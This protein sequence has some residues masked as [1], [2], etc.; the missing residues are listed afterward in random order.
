MSDSSMR[1]KPSIDDPSNMI[2]VQ[3]VLELA[4]GDLDVLHRP[5]DVGELQRR[6][7][8]FS[9]SARSRMRAFWAAGEGPVGVFEGMRRQL[10]TAKATQKYWRAAEL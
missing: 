10:L 9:A 8:T 5:E 7:F 2:A 6:N 1:T 4:V 3:R